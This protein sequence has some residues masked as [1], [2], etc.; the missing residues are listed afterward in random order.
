[1]VG[2]RIDNLRKTPAW[3][4]LFP[5]SGPI[6]LESLKK[7]TGL[8]LRTA[9]HEVIY[10][11]GGRHRLALIRGKFVDGGIT[12]AGLEPELKIEGAQKFPYKGFT[13]VG[14]E[15]EAVTFFNSSVAVVGRASA[16]RAIIDNRELKN[17]VPVGL[18]A[19][20]DGLP[21]ESHFYVVSNAPTLP[22]GGIGGVRSLPLSL[23]SVKAYLDMR[24]GASLRA[25]AEGTSADDAKKLIDALRG[26]TSLLRMTLKGDQKEM[27]GMLDA[28]QF[29]QEGAMVRIQADLSLDALMNGFKSL[30][31]L[32]AGRA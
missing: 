28:M 15:E 14:K 13:L 18:L 6:A 23:K 32:G 7:Q 16:L 3:D 26:I 5:A 10:C 8:D 29:Y 17:A 9:M 20:V 2:A 31:L 19:M 4:K 21:P 12:N 24:T 30:D 22:Q 25:E 1:L 11:S 27:L